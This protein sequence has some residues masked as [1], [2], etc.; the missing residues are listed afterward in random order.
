MSGDSTVLYKSV[1]ESGQKIINLYPEF[2]NRLG[3]K[4]DNRFAEIHF[5][6]GKAYIKSGMFKKAFIH[7]LESRRLSKKYINPSYIIS[8]FFRRFNDR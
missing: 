5:Q 8:R 7:F 1:L 4:V 2:K 6:L 3:S